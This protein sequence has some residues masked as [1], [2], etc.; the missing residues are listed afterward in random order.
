M[1]DTESGGQGR[2]CTRFAGFAAVEPPVRRVAPALRAR[3]HRGL[4]GLSGVLLFACMFLPAVKGCH[5]PVMPYEVPPFLPPYLYGLVFALIAVSRTQRGLERGYAALRVLGAA[6]VLGSV[7]LIV[8]TPELG[9]IE[10]LIGTVLLVTVAPSGAAEVRIAACGLEVAAVCIL[11]F[12]G[13]W[14]SDDALL[15]IPLSFA[16]SIGLFVGCL[17]WLRA[18]SRPGVEMPRAITL[19]R[20]RE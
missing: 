17:A 4:T 3:R 9:V 12:G 2:V 8:I 19:V 15:G 18:V 20:L 7:A 13:W 11:W 14:M 6:V 10:L 16:S 1:G 5:E